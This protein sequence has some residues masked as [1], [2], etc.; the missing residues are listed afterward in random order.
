MKIILT[1]LICLCVPLMGADKKPL[2]KEE[3]AKVIEEAIREHLKKPKGEL[4]KAVLEKVTE[5]ELSSNRMTDVKGLEKLTQLE[6]LYLSGNQLSD[7]KGLEK[8][9]QLKA[10]GLQSNKLTE[11][12]KGL[13]K[14]TQLKGLELTGNQLTDVKGLEK[15]TQLTMLWLNNNQLTN[16]QGLEKLNQLKQ[17]GLKNNQMTE[18]P[19]GLEKLTQLE[20]L[21][22]TGNKLTDVKGLEKLTK[23]TRL[24][25]TKNPTLTKTQIA[26][27]RKALP[28][29][30]VLPR[31][32]ASPILRRLS[33][34]LVKAF[35]VNQNL[36]DRKG[37]HIFLSDECILMEFYNFPDRPLFD[38]GKVTL[39]KYGKVIFQIVAWT[40]AEHEFRKSTVIEVAGHAG[41]PSKT[42]PENAEAESLSKGWAF[43]VRDFLVESGMKKERFG[44]VA[45]YGNRQPSKDIKKS[46]L[47]N[48]RIS[49]S[50]RLKGK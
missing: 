8:L 48:N 1:V 31:A 29:A 33:D 49:I 21:D 40:L 34:S 24:D 28:A 5:L 14:L 13:E 43:S 46:D 7:V 35:I 36:F 17:L 23:L 38:K 3:S 16:V 45:G 32:M 41:K 15:L 25:I 11:L 27:L 2:T 9:D 12:P 26:E 10:L 50:V 47:H 18:L 30:D 19:K 20:S 22:L 44:K 6:M 39:S 42:G 37:L 4:T